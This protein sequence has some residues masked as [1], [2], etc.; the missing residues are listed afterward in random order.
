MRVVPG[1]LT[2]VSLLMSPAVAPAQVVLVASVFDG[3]VQKYDINGTP[4]GPLVA[5]GGAS[6]ISGMALSPDNSTLFVSSQGT[7]QILKFNATTGVPAGAINLPA[8]SQPAG[9]KFGP[10]GNLY[11]SLFGPGVVNKYDP[12]T[13]TPAGTVMTGLASPSGLAFRGNTVY[14]ANLGA[15]NVQQANFD[16]TGQ[17][18]IVAPG[19]GG[20]QSP[21]GQSIGPGDS[22]YVSDLFG[23]AIRKYDPTGVAGSNSLGD[24][25]AGPQLAN[26]FP[27]DIIFFGGF[28]WVAN[29][30]PTQGAPLGT[31]MR[32]NETTGAFVD[33]FAT[34]LFSASTLVI[35]PE[36]SS[37][38]LAGGA[39]AAWR[40]ARRRTP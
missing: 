4:L 24:F 21:I 16:G 38:V 32:F 31:V 35:V 26:Q 36:P 14:A 28:A 23:S 1:L 8:G 18:A 20:L 6:I 7:D 3:A 29:L 12:V 37:I 9:L 27:S 5:P 22:L 19:S 13:G 15:G 39:I 25:N 33:T 40:L 30:G 17:T 34:G 10:D 2:V 11:A